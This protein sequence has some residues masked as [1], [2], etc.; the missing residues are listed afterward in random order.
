[1]WRDRD[2]FIEQLIALCLPAP[3][4]TTPASPQVVEASETTAP[5][6][7]L[8]A[9]R[10]H[11]I[12]RQAKKQGSQDYAIAYILFGAGLLPAELLN[13]ERSHYISSSEQ[14]L[15]DIRHGAVRQVPINQW[16]MGKRHGS[17][18]NNPLSQ[19]LKSRKDGQ[20][21]LFINPEAQPLT[22]TELQSIWQGFTAISDTTTALPPIAIE[23]AR[24]TWCI[25]MLT[26]GIS[27]EDLSI[28][29]GWDVARLQPYARRA[30]EKA[31]LELA[32]RLDRREGH[33]G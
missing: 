11:G 17:H 26:K 2:D 19:W 23:Q 12:L 3:P 4:A 30:R 13:L 31:A 21:A 29:S 8:P 16:I 20:T 25:E 22:L 5:A 15:L 7:D 10:V 6:N 32:I 24:H 27:I 28:L 1:M 18:T 9:G 33:P 14:H